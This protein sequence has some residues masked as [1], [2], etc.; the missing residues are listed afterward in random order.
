MN[1]TPCFSSRQLPKEIRCAISLNMKA[2]LQRKFILIASMVAIA[3]VT[4]PFGTF[5][6]L[7]LIERFF[8]WAIGISLISVCM[9]IGI[10]GMSRMRLLKDRIFAQVLAGAVLAG[11]FGALIILALD[12]YFRG[13]SFTLGGIGFRWVFVSLVGLGVGLIERSIRPMLKKSQQVEL[14]MPG[15]PADEAATPING[16]AHHREPPLF[17]RNLPENLGHSIISISTQDHYLDVVTQDGSDRILKRMSDA[18]AELNGYPGM[19]IHRSHWVALDA[20]ED[21]E[22]D[23]R[24]VRVR[25]KNG[26]VLPVSRPNVEPLAAALG[27]DEQ[28]I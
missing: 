23:G 19:Q 11:P 28:S 17:L 10:E 9:I 7:S 13:V 20:I 8:Y 26:E 27:R 2:G 14:V 21:M 1:E 24:N 16:A 6:Q 5:E 3:T 25:L 18:I 15:K 4:G 22:R 12:A